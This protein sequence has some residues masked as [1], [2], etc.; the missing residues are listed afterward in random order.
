MTRFPRNLAH[1]A[2]TWLCLAALPAL[3]AGIAAAPFIAAGPFLRGPGLAQKLI[4]WDASW[5]VNIALTGYHWRPDGAV[6]GHNQNIAYFPL[7][8]LIER[9]LNALAPAATPWSFIAA[10]LAFGVWSNLAFLRFAGAL[11]PPPAARRAALFFA[12]W[13]AA[14]FLAMGYPTGL[15]NLLAIACLRDRLLG[16]TWRAIIWAGL[17]TALSPTSVF[18]AAALCLD[19]AAAWRQDGAA[20]AALPRLAAQCFTAMAGLAAFAFYQQIAFG[21]AFAF[22]K[23]QGGFDPATPV[24][25]HL[26]RLFNPVWYFLPADFAFQVD[27]MALRDHL[28]ATAQGRQYLNIGFQW[29]LDLLA[30]ALTLPALLSHTGRALPRLIRLTGWCVLLGFL[31]FTATSPINITNGMRMLFPEFILFL[32]LGARLNNAPAT[33]L[34]A[35]LALLTAAETALVIAGYGVI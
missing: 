2:P 33:L 14:C 3:A 18:I 4:A 22:V 23:A 7:F 13:P 32:V 5:Y 16:Q 29:T 30:L 34:A 10:G 35:L 12:L 6:W 17:A 26:I 27:M 31:W 28:T 24:T 21:D 9:A 25:Y 20:P 15:I 11:L 8:A 1:A 19:L